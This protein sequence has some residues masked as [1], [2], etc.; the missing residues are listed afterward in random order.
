MRKLPSDFPED[1]SKINNG[2]RIE[3]ASK[4]LPNN[5]DLKN[6]NAVPDLRFNFDFSKAF[7]LGEIE[8]GNVTTINY[9]NT[10]QRIKTLRTRFLDFDPVKEESQVQFQFM[11]EQYINAVRFGVISN[12][13]FRF[14]DRHKIEFKNMF[15]QLGET[16]T[17]IRTG[18]NFIQ[19]P[20][21]SLRNYSFRYMSRGIYSGQLS[22]THEF[23]KDKSSFH[24]VTG[25]SYINRKLPD[26]RR[27]RTYKSIGTD[28][29]YK[30]IIPPT[31]TTFDASRFYSTLKEGTIMT[32]GDYENKL[33]N[34]EEDSVGIVLK[35]GYYVEM[36][37]RTFAARWMSYKSLNNQAA[38]SLSALPINQIFAQQNIDFQNG[39]FLTEGTNPSDA[40]EA[41]N[42]LTAGYAGIMIPVQ[43][44]KIATGAR[45]EYNRQQLQSATQTEKV[46][47]D[48]PITSLLPFMNVSYD[49]TKKM[50]LRAAYSRTINRPE[51][52]E[53]APFLFYDFDM[54]FDIV[55]NP[56][57]TIANI[58]NMDLRWEL[59]PAK[60][61]MITLGLFYKRFNNPIESYIRQGADNPIYTFNNALFANNIGVELEIRKSLDQL[62]SAQF[63][64]DLAFVFNASL[65]THSVDLGDNVTA[66][67]RTRALQGQSPYVANM[68][69]SYN[70]EKNGLT[71]SVLYNV[72]GKRI[73]IVGDKL[74]PTVYEMPRHLIDITV[75]K[76][77]SEKFEA[78]VGVQ[79]LLN[80]R[81]DYIQDSNQDG[82]ITGVD[83]SV[84]SFRRGA[85]YT[86]GMNYRF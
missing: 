75:I 47:V 81:A 70:S 32:S 24:W 40:Y 3:D 26:L 86:F 13:L 1:L 29:P 37:S 6:K 51:F 64:K 30:V 68:G 12:W 48:N 84:I 53:I 76:K 85:Y 44:F 78:R 4:S 23:K 43:K 54:N 58:H 38:D 72:I 59:Y 67:D 11:D 82:E 60:E 80:Y 74:N 27:L 79:D 10:Y 34:A 57:L 49:L 15:N 2:Q 52:R 71:V 7:S 17:T 77:L 63:I 83:E 22:G 61:E 73:F 33:F 56:D 55:G 20:T 16:E 8:S 5:F 41:Q 9:S 36:K 39:F 50:L 65:I 45:L 66:Q 62:S 69:L 28:D 42:L 46:N 19:R 25:F 35:A 14:N 31:A 18:V 21:D